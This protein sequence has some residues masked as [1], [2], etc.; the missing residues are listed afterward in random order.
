MCVFV[1]VIMIIIINPI[2]ILTIIY[3]IFFNPSTGKLGLL[4]FEF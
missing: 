4:P 3:F 2:I 1:C